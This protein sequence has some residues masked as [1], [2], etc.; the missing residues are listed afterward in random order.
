MRTE[1]KK[2]LISKKGIVVKGG[3]VK[4]CEGFFLPSSGHQPWR[5]HHFSVLRTT[6][7]GNKD[8]IR[9]LGEEFSLG[10]LTM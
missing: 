8:R 6:L 5:G 7:R 1:S 10:L 2:A 9:L 3:K 4:L